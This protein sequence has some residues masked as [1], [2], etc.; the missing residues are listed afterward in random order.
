MDRPTRFA[1]GL[2][3]SSLYIRKGT[4]SFNN[5]FVEWNGTTFVNRYL[6]R[7]AYI[8]SVSGGIHGVVALDDNYAIL[9]NVGAVL[10]PGYA[11]A[12]N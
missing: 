3:P 12:P 1:Y 2:N 7:M 5:R 11:F 6:A 4:T 10:A 8:F 9:C